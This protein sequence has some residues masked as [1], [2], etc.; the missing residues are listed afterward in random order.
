[1]LRPCFY[2][3]S[4]GG[5]TLRESLPPQVGSPA[6][7]CATIRADLSASRSCATSRGS[8]QTIPSPMGRLHGRVRM[9]VAL[10]LFALSTSPLKASVGLW[11]RG[12][13]PPESQPIYSVS[14][15]RPVLSGSLRRIARLHR[16]TRPAS[17]CASTGSFWSASRA[18]VTAAVA[19][20]LTEPHPASSRR[21][22][23]VVALRL[24][25]RSTSPLGAS[26]GL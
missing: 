23:V 2:P 13:R 4:C 18:C 22:R 12:V 7:A 25:A 10:R 5:Q 24:F 9:V 21:V 11:A 3:Q 8:R 14:I 6:S 16:V 17:V 19:T 26:A 20:D 1:M 15:L